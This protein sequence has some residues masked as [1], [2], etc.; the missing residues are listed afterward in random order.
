MQREQM[1]QIITA[2][3]YQSLSENNLQI[4]AIPP[5][6]LQGL[7]NA[8]ADGVFAAVAAAEAEGDAESGQRMAAVP[9]ASEGASQP[10]EQKL[11][12]GRPYLSIGLVYEL[13]TQRLRI[14]RGILG[15]T[16]DEVELVR[17]KDTRVKQHLGERVLDVGDVTIISND[18][19]QP[20]VVLHNVS[21]P[22]E[23][24]ELIR[25]ATNAEKERRGL[26]YREDM[27]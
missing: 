15:S 13:T 14:L 11:W 1:R 19:S 2:Q 24:R 18:P 7:I 6:E 25:K 17:I 9:M 27:S 22:I 12:R 16:I 3:V 4:K 8:L 10:E 26:R 21:N 23:V 20:E 5:N